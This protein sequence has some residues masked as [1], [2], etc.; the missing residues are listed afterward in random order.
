MTKEQFRA[1]LAEL[2]QNNNNAILEKAEKILNSG[3]VDLASCE[4]DYRLPKVFMYAVLQEM[5]CRW[6]PL[7]KS[8]V[9]EANNMKYFM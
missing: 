5:V 9:K 3:C 4:D 1:K 6:K 2:I 8:L 7:E